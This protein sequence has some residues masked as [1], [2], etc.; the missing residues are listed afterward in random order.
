MSRFVEELRKLCGI[1]PS[2]DDLDR[3]LVANSGLTVVHEA[4]PADDIIKLRRQLTA[5]LE[6]HDLARIAGL[7][8]RLV[9]TRQRLSNGRSASEMAIEALLAPIEKLERP[10][11]RE[12]TLPIYEAWWQK[13]RGDPV[14]AGAYAYALA[15]TGLAYRGEDWACDVTESQWVL[16]RDF[17]NRA[18]AVVERAG[19][20]RTSSWIWNRCSMRVLFVAFGVSEASEHEVARAFEATMR[21]D[22]LEVGLYEE[23]VYHLLPR[24]GG[25]FEALE[26]FARQCYATTRGQLGSEMYARIY[27]IIVRYEEPDATLLDY[28]LMCEGFS[29]WLQRVPSQALAN[30]YAAHAHAHR[31][32]GTLTHLFTQTIT[33]IHPRHWFAPRQPS[34][35]WEAV[36]KAHLLRH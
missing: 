18:Q 3:K 14:A 35:A 16:L 27:D 28:S 23:R 1:V 13:G 30:R 10:E 17:A 19:E 26:Q 34:L 33:E 4:R 2:I 9:S 36:S 24:W 5:L 22:P 32:I 11:D 21:L 12:A 15:A 8:E 20:A 7:C 6:Q 29:N 31:D 25:S